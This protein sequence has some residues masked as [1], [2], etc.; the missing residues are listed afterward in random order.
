[1]GWNH[2][3]QKQAAARF[4]TLFS[5]RTP[6]PLSYGGRFSTRPLLVTYAYSIDCIFVMLTN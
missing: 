2:K 5:A 1:M 6:T 4:Q 3:E